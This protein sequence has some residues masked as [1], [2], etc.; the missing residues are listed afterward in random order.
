MKRIFF[1]YLI[2]LAAGAAF[3][4][5]AAEI[6]RKVDENQAF[7]SIEYTGRMEIVL[8]G[9]TRVKTMRT[10]AVGDSKAFV[11][12]TNPEDRGT[13]M[14]KLDKNLWMYFPKEQ[15]TV[16]ISGHLLKEGMMGSDVSYEDAMESDALLDK[17]SASVL[18]EEAVEGRPAWVLELKAKVPTATYD[19]RLVWIDKERY[20]SLKGEMYARSGKLLKESRS[21][22][23]RNIGGRWYPV[24][25]EMVNRLRKDTRTVFVLEDLKLD[26]RIPDSRFSM[27][28]LTK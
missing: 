25:T 12:F 16:K 3:G 22:E 18:R 10:W 20:V 21:L 27:A 1:V 6:L 28:E 9:D 8:G 13:R 4:Q 15:D 5:T 23:V 2:T 14:L 24:R 17:Y 7:Q 11:E 19:R 26:T